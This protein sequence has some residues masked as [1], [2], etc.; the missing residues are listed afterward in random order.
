MTKARQTGS[1]APADLELLLN[2]NGVADKTRMEDTMDEI[3]RR[4]IELNTGD[5]DK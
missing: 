3:E 4:I 2:T 5:L 1:H